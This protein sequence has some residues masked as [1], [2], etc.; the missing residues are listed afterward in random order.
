[1]IISEINKNAAII[2]KHKRLWLFFTFGAM[3]FFSC[4]LFPLDKYAGGENIKWINIMTFIMVFISLGDF[5]RYLNLY[6]GKLG[7][8]LLC[9]SV[10]IVGGLFCRYLI[11]FGEISNVYNFTLG[12]IAM[13]VLAAILLVIAGFGHMSYLD[14]TSVSK[15]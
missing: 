4:C 15:S 6:Q 9:T 12:N 11:E 1:M 8:N 2:N 7:L 5:L 13:F 3:V 14:K 10:A